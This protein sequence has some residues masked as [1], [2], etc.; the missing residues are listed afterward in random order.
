MCGL[1]V[2][3]AVPA[4]PGYNPL[5]YSCDKT[6]PGAAAAG[7]SCSWGDCQAVAL[8]QVGHRGGAG[9]GAID[10]GAPGEVAAP[11]EIAYSLLT[12]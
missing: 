6:A 11:P 9:G 10:D 12:E 4:C 1:L 5:T 2:E 7:T 8:F 3:Q